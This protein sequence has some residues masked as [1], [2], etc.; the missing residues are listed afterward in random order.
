MNRRAS[1]LLAARPSSPEPWPST[2]KRRMMQAKDAK[3][4]AKNREEQLNR[5]RERV[6]LE[7][8]RNEV[9][10]HPAGL[11]LRLFECFKWTLP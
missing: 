1:L 6:A 2:Q 7:R 3:Q 11:L 5:L 4:E 9:R 8:N 10:R